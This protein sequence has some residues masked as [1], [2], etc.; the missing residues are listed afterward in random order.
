MMFFFDSKSRLRIVSI[1]RRY[2]FL[3]QKGISISI[4]YRILLSIIRKISV[5]Y[6]E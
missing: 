3:K 6:R 1:D 5:N 2:Y 4:E